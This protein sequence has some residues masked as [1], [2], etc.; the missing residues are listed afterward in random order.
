MRSA[1][2]LFARGKPDDLGLACHGLSERYHKAALYAFHLDRT[3]IPYLKSEIRKRAR[4][5]AINERWPK[6]AIASIEEM[7]CILMYDVEK[8]GRTTMQ[9]R[10]SAIPVVREAL[11][12]WRKAR[13]P[14][15]DKVTA[16]GIS[17]AAWYRHYAK[18]YD[19]LYADV[20]GWAMSGRSHVFRQDN[21]E[22]LME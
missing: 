15:K 4:Y 14:V 7:I 1:E 20:I 17:E 9:L 12:N 8:G 13:V 16:L 22:E 18:P 19:S 3:V 6:Q 2:H 5:Y 10:S 21:Y 11:I